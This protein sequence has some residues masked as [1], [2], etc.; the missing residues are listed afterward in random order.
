MLVLRASLFFTFAKRTIYI[1]RR[2]ALEVTIE[3]P[4]FY[5]TGWAFVAPF[6]KISLSHRYVK[7]CML[8]EDLIKG[9]EVEKALEKLL[10][11]L[12]KGSG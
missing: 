1:S 7:L 12:G 6:N 2:L 5:C 11:V 4:L 9:S 3:T 10:S 8:M